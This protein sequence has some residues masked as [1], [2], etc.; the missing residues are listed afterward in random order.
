M[1]YFTPNFR[2]VM[3]LKLDQLSARQYQFLQAEL[4]IDKSEWTDLAEL[5]RFFKVD[6][7][8]QLQ[9]AVF[10]CIDDNSSNWLRVS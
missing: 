7:F 8:G 1:K 9:A 10:N 2:Q 3:S 4:Q 5:L 6:T